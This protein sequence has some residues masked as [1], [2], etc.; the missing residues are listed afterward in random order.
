MQKVLRKRIFRDF[1]E[2]LPRYLALAFLLILSMYMVVSIVGA[3]ET[4]MRGT[5]TEAKKQNVE[6]G[7]FSLFVP[8]KESEWD[9]LTDKG[10][11]LEKMFFLDYDVDGDK[12]LR[13][14]KNRTKID[15]IAIHAGKLAQADDE[16][17]LERQYAEKNDIHVGDTIV[18][19]DRTYKVSGIGTVP[20][21]D[22]PLKSLGD[23]VCDSLNFGL[24]FVT[25]E[26]YTILQTEGKSE[27]SE[28]YYYA[29]KLNDA[30]TDDELN[31]ELK[32]LSFS[33]DDVDDAYFQEYWDRT[34]GREEEFRD[35]INE[36][37]DG[38]KELADGLSELTDNNHDLQ[39]ASDQ[40][41]A[42]Y[43][44]QANSKLSAY[45]VEI[46]TADNFEEVLDKQIRSTNN[47]MLQLGLVNAKSEL[48]KLKAFSDGI[49]E[50]TDGTA[51]AADGAVDVQ[52]G[53]QELKDET[54]NMLDEIFNADADNLLSFVTAEDNV[55]I[56]AAS[57]DVEMNNTIGMIAGVLLLV[58][59]AYVLSVFVVHSID[60][61]SAVIG[62]LYALGVKRKDLMRHYI[63]LPT[64]ISLIGGAIGTALAYTKIGVRYQM[65]DTYYYYYYSLPDIAVQIRPY[66]IVYGVAIPPI[67]CLVVT[68]L[69]IRKRLSRPVLT[70]LKNEQKA[71][72]GKDVKLGNM[73]FM[74]LFR[75]RQ[76]L[77]E[78][79]TALTVVFGMFVSILLL[80]MSMEIYVYCRAV[81]DDYVADTK[82]EYMYTYKYPGEEVPDGGYEAYAKT[83]KKEIYGYNFD[84]TVL[85]IRENNPFF[86]VT[87]SDSADKVTISSS[88]SYKYGLKKGDVIT[89]KD[90]ENGKIYAF[91]IEAV[92]QY[93]P[94]F[95][96]FLP[97]EKALDLFG[98]Q[99]DYY[100]VVFADHDLGVE[101]GRLYS[102]MTRD[103]VKKAAGIFS[104]QMRS[105]I[106]TIG[107]VSALIFAIVLYLMM[108]VMIDRSSFS[109][110]L[111]KIFGYRNK[112]VKKMYLDGNFYIVLLGALVSIPLAKVLLDAVYE[113]QFVPNIACG[114]DKSFP[115]WLYLA[116]FAGVL[117]LYFIINHLLVRKIKQMLP[118]EVLKNRE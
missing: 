50:Y 30:M 20:D 29:Y 12:T 58:L 113:P 3:A 104:D 26:A 67:I 82:F 91:E 43:L 94:S 27:K 65:Q 10:I 102:T 47:A 17:V 116:M 13:V 2:N 118:A 62:A 98:E 4:V 76:I 16:L 33:S 6:D 38:A 64:L 79:R 36:L 95:M 54:E 19:G 63:L 5:T 34:L 107:A 97:Y 73:K 93:A 39:K 42:A 83:L 32:Q 53:V 99:D 84:V 72:K 11:T 100:N 44:E 75:I 59:I 61:E 77:R 46:L 55:R 88:I 114:V 52:D 115:A 66:T 86:D 68:S 25:D 90:E 89:L 14:F 56:H 18:L 78:R 51:D 35:G 45:R 103:D 22:S 9:A 106:I 49:Y 28:E 117:V 96:V 8:M 74:K 40:I 21:Y 15:T 69:V 70:L 41:F 110:A 23:T 109:I 111:I 80:V 92:T 57:D 71:A 37:A 85:G 108:K 105:M 60:Q 7:Q 48:Q 87:L 24:A 31:A 81:Q 1:K 101:S 112:E